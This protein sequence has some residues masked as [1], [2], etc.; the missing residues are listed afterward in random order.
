MDLDKDPELTPTS[1][2]SKVR[3]RLDWSQ[4]WS[5]PYVK[6]KKLQ[7]KYGSGYGSR[8]DPHW[9]KVRHRWDW[10]W[11]ESASLIKVKK[12]Q[13]KYGSRSGYGVDPQLSSGET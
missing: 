9:A 2:W 12:L 6:V 5:G 4:R 11:R 10:S 8:V 3:H 1:T 7:P 13:P